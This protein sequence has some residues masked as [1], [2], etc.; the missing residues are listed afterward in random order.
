MQYYYTVLLFLDI[1]LYIISVQM[2]NPRDT[3]C[4]YVNSKSIK[5]LTLVDKTSQTKTEI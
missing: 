1:C 5:I 4:T 3:F 2:L